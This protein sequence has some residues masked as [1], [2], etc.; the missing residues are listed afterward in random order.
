MT[1]RQERDS[2][3][4]IDVP[5]DRLWGAQTQ[6]SLQYFRISKERIPN[7]VILA[8]ADIKRSAALVNLGLGLLKPEKAS[9]IVQAA[10]EVL[11]GKHKLEFMLSVWQTGSGTQT[12]SG[13]NTYTGPTTVTRGM[14]R[15]SPGLTGGG[16]GT[17]SL[18]L[19]LVL[20]AVAVAA[21][22]FAIVNDR[23][24]TVTRSASEIAELPGARRV[25][26]DE[27]ARKAA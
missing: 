3:G 17:F 2:F 7:E 4:P 9:A 19:V 16:S 15:G 11:A 10:D 24:R 5:S 26:K 14:D 21:V 6:R 8:L 25:D 23:R 20:A 13:S 22:G 18:I 1:T 27:S 12:F